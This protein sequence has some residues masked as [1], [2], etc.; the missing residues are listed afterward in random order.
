MNQPAQNPDLI[1]KIATRQSLDAARHTGR[2]A[3]MPVD[4]ADGYMHF[5]TASQL[6]ET[7]RLHFRGQ[8]DLILLAVRTADLGDDLVWEASR[9][10][11][12]FPHLYNGP[13]V[14][15]AVAWEEHISVSETGECILPEAVQ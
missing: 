14:L 10:G 5:S 9:G 7:L 15:D 3:G 6:A 1:Y 4:A 2:Y 11:A 12:L 8:R 13:L